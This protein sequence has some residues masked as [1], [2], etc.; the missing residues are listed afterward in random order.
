M[1]KRFYLG[2]GILL[3]ILALGI[4]V[5]AGMK[6]IHQPVKDLLTQAADQA[7]EENMEQALPLAQKAYARWQRYHSITA[8]L[9]DHSPMDDT[10]TLF[11]ELLVYGRMEEIPHFAAC[12]RELTVMVEAMYDAHA[13]LLKNLL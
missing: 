10:D 2:L 7:L 8:S 9:A 1:E 3:V 12:C 6:V 5:A 4:G 13:F 11:Q